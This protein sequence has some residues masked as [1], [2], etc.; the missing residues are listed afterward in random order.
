MICRL[1]LITLIT[2]TA[3]LAHAERQLITVKIVGR[4][5]HRS[6]VSK[7]YSNP[8]LFGGSD[9]TAYTQKIAG[10]DLLLE[11]PDGRIAVAVCSSKYAPHFDY[12]N[13]RSCRVPLVIQVEAEFNR[14]RVKLFWS[15][16]LNNS[17]Q[18]SETYNIISVGTKDAL[19]ASQSIP[20]PVPLLSSQPTMEASV[21]TITPP[22]ATPPISPINTATGGPPAAG[23]APA[24][25]TAPSRPKCLRNDDVLALK[26]AGFSD[27]IILQRIKSTSGLYDV[28]TTD[29]VKL[30]QAGLSQ[31]VIGAM[32]ATP[33]AH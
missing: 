7:S 21:P 28:D 24:P 4:A 22:V 2:S 9:S 30:K 5:D 15:T 18:Q 14:D 16:S 17:K 29:L 13:R 20:A 10:H 32:I 31:E 33:T 1:Y 6:S 25:M 19:V 8:G 26:Q 23:A 27:D 3:L 11:L 12:V